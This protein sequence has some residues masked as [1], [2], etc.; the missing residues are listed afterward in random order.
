MQPPN[1]RGTLAVA[2]EKDVTLE[3]QW[4]SLAERLGLPVLGEV[5]PRF[6][7]QHP[8]LLLQTRRGLVLQHTGKGVPGPVLADFLHGKA[9]YRRKHGGGRGQLIAKAVGI[10]KRSQPLTVLDATAGLGQD[11]FV[12]ATLG[13]HVSLL[14]RS[15][16]VAALLRDGIERL[17]GSEEGRQLAQRM[18]LTEAD[19]AQWLRAQPGPV[20]DIVYLDPMFPHR[21]NSARVKKEMTA[22]QALVGGDEDADELLAQALAKA[23]FR[24]VVKRPRKAPTLAGPEPELV[25]SGRSTRYDVYTLAAI[26]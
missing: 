9:D 6:H 8:L 1:Y 4:Q 21:G 20:A 16:V 25:L 2:A 19:S 17:S 13:A 22:F 5:N 7:L 24:V 11:A 23:R 14:E 26:S 18:S 10:G 3:P 15:P 12:L